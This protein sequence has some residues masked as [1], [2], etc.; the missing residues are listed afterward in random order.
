MVEHPTT[1]TYHHAANVAHVGLL[2]TQRKVRKDFFHATITL[3]VEISVSPACQC[4]G[5]SLEP[6]WGQLRAQR[7]TKVLH[8]VDNL[9]DP[10]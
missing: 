7:Y 5:G 8:G 6:T 9:T 4:D 1:R 3:V 10:R 2:K